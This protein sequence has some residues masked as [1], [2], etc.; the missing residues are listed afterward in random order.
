MIDIVMIRARI[1]NIQLEDDA[2]AYLAQVGGR[3]SLR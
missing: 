2:L 1:E 3:T